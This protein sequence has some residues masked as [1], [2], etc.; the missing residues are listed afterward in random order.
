MIRPARPD[1]VPEIAAMIREL[2]EYEHL[3]H[4]VRLNEN[5]L[6]SDLFGPRKSARVLIAEDQGGVIGFALYFYNYSTFLGRPGIHL[7]D[8]F[9]RPPSRGRGHGK[10]LLAHLAAIAFDEN[11]GRLEWSVL[12]WNAPSIA[13][14]KKLG[15]QPMDDWTTFRLTG[16]TLKDVALMADAAK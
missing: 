9:I 5:D 11:C 16:D 8:L 4:E 14:Y 7:E 13:F 2:A 12:D 3:S 15:A 10:A 6:R 1:D